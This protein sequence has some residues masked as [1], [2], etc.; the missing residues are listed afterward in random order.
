MKKIPLF[1]L[2]ILVLVGCGKGQFQ[3]TE[4]T[5]GSGYF[6]G[7]EPLEGRSRAPEMYTVRDTTTNAEL[8]VEDPKGINLNKFKAVKN[9]Y[10]KE[11]PA[12]WQQRPV[13]VHY[14]RVHKRWWT[15]TAAD[16][17]KGNI[18]FSVEYFVT[19]FSYVPVK[20]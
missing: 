15:G 8:L 12:K 10:S 13:L 17:T 5:F 1:T 14:R 19:G 4:L 3:Q 9:I 20:K 6:Y 11:D 18:N 7:I 2:V 16:S